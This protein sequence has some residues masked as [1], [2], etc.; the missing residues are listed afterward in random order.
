M[1]PAA[2]VDVELGSVRTRAQILDVSI[3]GLRVVRPGHLPANV[4]QPVELSFSQEDGRALVLGGAV[5]RAVADELA[6]RFEP[7]A[8]LQE[9]ALRALIQRRGQRRDR[10]GDNDAD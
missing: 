1:D 9:D 4:G 3:S 8:P 6:F 10:H 2:G 7:M 5:V